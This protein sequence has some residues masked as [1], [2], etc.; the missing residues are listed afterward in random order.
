MTSNRKAKAKTGAARNSGE[1]A[2]A[3]L[4]SKP[5]VK[6]DEKFSCAGYRRVGFGITMHC[7]LRDECYRFM[8]NDV[9]LTERNA[10]PFALRGW[11][12]S[13]VECSHYDGPV[14]TVVSYSS[15]T[16]TGEFS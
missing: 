7:P 2:K 10:A 11:S 12:R 8:G 3:F 14:A 9:P 4:E 16:I 6:R 5:I 15:I 1:A 13:E